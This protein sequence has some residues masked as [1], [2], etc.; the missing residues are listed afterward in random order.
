MSRVHFISIID[1]A[2]GKVSSKSNTIFRHFRRSGKT[3][4]MEREE[5]YQRTRSAKQRAMRAAFGAKSRAVKAWLRANS[6]PPTAAYLL[7]QR[8]F[9]SQMSCDNFYN[10]LMTRWPYS[11]IACAHSVSDQRT[12]LGEMEGAEVVRPEKR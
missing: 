9:E 2:S 11:P 10:Y 12:A 8:D 5:N 1:Y 7:L 4:T 6:N 3:F